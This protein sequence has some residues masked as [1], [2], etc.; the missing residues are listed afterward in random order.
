MGRS[1]SRAHSAWRNCCPCCRRADIIRSEMNGDSTPPLLTAEQ[2][3]VR[4]GFFT[5][6]RDV[7]LSL[8]G[9]EL[10]GLIG[11]NG[12]GKTTLLRALAG[13]QPLSRGVV[14]VLGEMMTPSTS[15]LMA[16]V[17]FTPDTP[18]MYED[19]TV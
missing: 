1:S 4:F 10:L 8:G 16:Q 18:P 13:I 3:T 11:P 14:R 9:G 7:N 5:A 19:L 12:A 15:H 17:G 6:V 2:V